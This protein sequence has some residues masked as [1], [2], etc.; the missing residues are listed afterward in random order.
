LKKAES[1]TES[2][3]KNC[4]KKSYLDETD[5]IADLEEGKSRDEMSYTNSK[6]YGSLAASRKSQPKNTKVIELSDDDISVVEVTKEEANKHI[7]S[8]E[9]PQVPQ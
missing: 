1:F 2:A 7:N 4:F 8:S 6:E 9:I 5:F 3:M